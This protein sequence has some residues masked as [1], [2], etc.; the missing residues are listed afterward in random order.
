M[1]V[2]DMILLLVINMMER[3]GDSDQVS[4]TYDCIIQYA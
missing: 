3:E 1:R 4:V 2:Q